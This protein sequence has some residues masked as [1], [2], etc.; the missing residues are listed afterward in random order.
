[1]RLQWL[2]ANGCEWDSSVNVRAEEGEHGAVA[3]WAR[4]NGCPEE[5]DSED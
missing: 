4:A 3:D 5:S 2:R 1:M